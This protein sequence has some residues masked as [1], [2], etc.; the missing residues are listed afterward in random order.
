[1]SGL[2]CSRVACSAAL[3]AAAA[4]SAASCNPLRARLVR[5]GGQASGL[6]VVDAETRRGRL[7]RAAGTQRPLASNMKLFTTSTALSRLGPEARIATRVLSDGRIDTH[8]V[9]HGSLYLKGGGD[10]TLGTP[11]FYDAL[12]RRPRHRTSTR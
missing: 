2:F 11:A 1:M 10:P 8:G 3:L 9:L 12:P 5:G 4:A 6:L 7:P